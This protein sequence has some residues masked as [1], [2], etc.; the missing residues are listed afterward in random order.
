VIDL[1]YIWRRTWSFPLLFLCYTMNASIHV[2]NL[3]AAALAPSQKQTQQRGSYSWMPGWRR[4][5]K[6]PQGQPPTWFC[7]AAAVYRAC[8]PLSGVAAA[9]STW[10]WS[11][12]QLIVVGLPSSLVTSTAAH[13]VVHAASALR[14]RRLSPRCAPAI[15][16]SSYKQL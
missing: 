8:L 13:K 1:C 9:P 11:A 4:R 16:R 12:Q 7:P 6:H 3:S 2:S 15:S 10:L 14:T 5:T